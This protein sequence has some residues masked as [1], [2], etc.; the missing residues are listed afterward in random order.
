MI[1]LFLV[2]NFR[3]HAFDFS[4]LIACAI[5][6]LSVIALVAMAKFNASL[7][8]RRFVCVAIA[9]IVYEKH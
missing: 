1:D 9:F 7:A 6:L 4:H 3:F 5:F 8:A 2:D